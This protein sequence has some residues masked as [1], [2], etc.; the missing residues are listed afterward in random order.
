MK[1]LTLCSVILIVILV[2]C[3]P[4]GLVVS[5]N[6]KVSSGAH[7]NNQTQGGGVEPK[8][9]TPKRKIVD[10]LNCTNSV[11]KLIIPKRGESRTYLEPKP[12]SDFLLE[13]LYTMV[14]FDPVSSPKNRFNATLYDSIFSKAQNVLDMLSELA[15]ISPQQYLSFGNM[16][17]LKVEVKTSYPENLFGL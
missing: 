4:T 12:Q 1:K 3:L 16:E 8:T 9:P 15:C 7:S 2:I 17:N 14:N 11:T 13:T 5:K 10:R 6:K